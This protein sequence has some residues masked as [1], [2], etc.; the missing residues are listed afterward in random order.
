M[1][2]RQRDG[3]QGRSP[4]GV[5]DDREIGPPGTR[6]TR[7][8]RA[9]SLAAVRETARHVELHANRVIFRG[10]HKIGSPAGHKQN[11][12]VVKLL[13][14][15]SSARSFNFYGLSTDFL[16]IG[17]KLAVPVPI[18]G[19]LLE[20]GSASFLWMQPRKSFNP[21]R[22]Q[23]SMIGTCIKDVYGSDDF[24]KVGLS[25]LDF[26]APAKGEARVLSV[27]GYEDLDLLSRAEL[28]DLLTA[29]A[30]A[31]HSL[32]K[33]GYSKPVRPTKEKRPDERQRDLF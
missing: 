14:D 32:V 3:I 23:L 1:R 21:N 2:R 25:I 17:K 13:C 4:P 7:K 28:S 6:K 8:T 20:E 10:A 9:S 18:E 12:E 29:F 27:Y 30:T 26:S 5:D 22:A 15:W 24:E 16:Q 31:Y 33:A 19:Y 11:A